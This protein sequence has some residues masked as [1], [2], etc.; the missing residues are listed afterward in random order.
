MAYTSLHLGP[1]KQPVIGAKTCDP[2]TPN[3][4]RFAGPV[5]KGIFNG[6]TR[7]IG[8]QGNPLPL[9]LNPILNTPNTLRIY[10]I[11]GIFDTR[12]VGVCLILGGRE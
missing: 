7:L 8:V 5:E 11:M 2:R 9:I 12:G 10:H 4:G 3:R 6:C 1:L